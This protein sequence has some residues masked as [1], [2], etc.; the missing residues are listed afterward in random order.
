MLLIHFSMYIKLFK[1]YTVEH[2][3]KILIRFYD[4]QNKFI[5]CVQHACYK[6]EEKGDKSFRFK[7]VKC[8]EAL[9]FAN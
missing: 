6:G 1:D 4:L 8:F 9:S 5:K 7:H 2:T 3:E